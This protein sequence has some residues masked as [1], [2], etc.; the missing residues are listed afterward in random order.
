[1]CYFCNDRAIPFSRTLEIH[2]AAFLGDFSLSERRNL[3]VDFQR[4]QLVSTCSN[5][6]TTAKR[7]SCVTSCAMLL[8]WTQALSCPNTTSPGHGSIM[9]GYLNQECDLLYLN[10]RLSPKQKE[11]HEGPTIS[12]FVLFKNWMSS[13][14]LQPTLS[15]QRGFCFCSTIQF[16]VSLTHQCLVNEIWLYSG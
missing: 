16:L 3:V 5:C 6:P 12:P 2:L 4:H 10:S 7:V 8:A 9:F 1:M 14:Q 11:R 15:H 13:A